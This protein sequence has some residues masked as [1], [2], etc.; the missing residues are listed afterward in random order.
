[1]KHIESSDHL[2]FKSHILVQLHYT[3]ARLMYSNI[4]PKRGNILGEEPLRNKIWIPHLI[5]NNERESSL[6]GLDGKDVFVQMSPSGEVRYSYRMTTT[7]Y[8]WMN[9][10]KFPFDYQICNLQWVSWPYNNTNIILQWRK[11]RPFQLAS[12]L[13]LTEF[14]LDDRWIEETVASS[15]FNTGGLTGNCSAV[16]FNF[17]LRRE[18]GYYIMDYFLP[19]ILL[20]ITSW[21]TFWLQADASAPR[22]TLGAST[23]L[24]FITLNGGLSKS[25]PKVSYIKASEIWFLGCATFIFCSIAEFAFVNVIWRRRKEV[26]LKKP[27]SKHILKGALTPSLARK[28][29]RKEESI[30]SLYKTRSCSSLDEEKSA[31]NTQANYLTV[32]SFPSSLHIPT[33]MTPESQDDLKGSGDSVTTI[34]IP[35]NA[36]RPPTPPAWTTMTPQ[37]VANWIDRKSRI[38]FP[39]A[40]FIFNLFY[41]SF[42]YAL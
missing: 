30:Y 7:F 26:E 8:C 1:M 29:L 4:S 40:F 31:K 41:W 36:S 16:V 32:H 33:I 3:D 39:V 19:S 35:D 34:P 22:M 28:Q 6:M 25:L 27:S 14:V 18:V 10:Q 24:S 2:Q 11:V 17:K 20:V 13:H 15:S 37:E 21:V 23:M 12:N 9:L 42:V 38:V 5:I